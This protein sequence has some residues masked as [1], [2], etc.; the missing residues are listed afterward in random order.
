L[1]TLAVAPSGKRVAASD[2][3]G[4]VQLWEVD[5]SRVGPRFEIGST[6]TALGFVGSDNLIATGG[7]AIQFWDAPTGRLWMTY[8]VPRVAVSTLKVDPQRVCAWPR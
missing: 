4:H 1:T 2:N 7:Q 8:D 5:L 6:I 3:R